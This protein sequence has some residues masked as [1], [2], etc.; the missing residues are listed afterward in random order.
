[1]IVRLGLSN[2]YMFKIVMIELLN[3]YCAV[4][5]NNILRKIQKTNIWINQAIYFLF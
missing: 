2:I 3:V 5:K 4:A 1:M